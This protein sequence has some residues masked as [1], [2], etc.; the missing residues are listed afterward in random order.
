MGSPT[1]AAQIAAVL[2]T[3]AAVWAAPTASAAGF[4][5]SFGTNGVSV[6]PLNLDASDRYQASV[7][8]PDGSTYSVGYTTL[9]GTTD[10]A[11][12][13]TKVTKAGK[14]DP[15]F[16]VGGI[17]TLNVVT[18]PF[19]AAPNAPSGAAQ[20]GPTGAGEIAQNVVV[21]SDGKI[22]VAGQAET[23]PS[24]VG[25]GKKADSRDT[26]IYAA[27]FGT[28]G[29]LDK[30]FGTNGV[31]RVDLSDG[32]Q[33]PSSPT[34]TTSTVRGD[35]VYGL[36]IRPDGRTLITASYGVDSSTNT[37]RADSDLAVVQLKTDGTP[38]ATFGNV[39]GKPGVALARTP[40]VSESVRQGY[41]SANGDFT[42]SAYATP[43]GEGTRPYIYRF[44][45]NGTLDTT[46]GTAGVASNPV[47]STATRAEAYGVVESGGKLY[48]AGY[49][50]R[51][52]TSSN[53]DATITRYNQDGS[54]DTSFGEGGIVFYDG[55]LG[56]GADRARN[57]K[58]LSDGRIVTAGG[59]TTKLAVPA[60]VG[61]PAVPAVP[62]ETKGLVLVLNQD[63]TFDKRFGDNGTFK[64]DFGGP[65][66]F[67]Y[68]LAVDGTTITVSAWRTG[69]TSAAADD[70][71]A[72]ARIDLTPPST[73]TPTT[74]TPTT[75]T[76]STT[77]PTTTTPTTTPKPPAKPA[78]TVGKVTVSAKRLSKS[79]IRVT[80]KL[81]RSGKGKVTV[82]AKRKGAKAVSGKGTITTKGT[83]KLTL[84]TGKKGKYT[85]TLKVPT[86]AGGTQTVKRTVTVR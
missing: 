7:A 8:G 82:S 84:K 58:T 64:V 42:T 2:A 12:A 67:L 32:V 56:T 41:V 63:G 1:R 16:G 73:T 77:T 69:P 47:P 31:T 48:V 20:S 75:T 54:P 29:K 19:A 15:S 49:G 60:V 71:A 78:K 85:L 26:D 62:A 68:G 33:V 65:T 3:G 40:G 61:P 37:T 14:L 25:P 80:L 86:P 45:S 44:K 38:D 55:G 34:A 70:D 57:I 11:F 79:R 53:T 50:A 17:A 24:E 74:T 52:A 83:L 59:V 51:A 28:D 35:Q 21:Q 9:P 30:T 10:R 46:F 43:T 76:P 6:T 81:Q 4:D 22:V 66:D 13:L 36:S 72:L 23:P 18:G 5:T 27:R 39:V